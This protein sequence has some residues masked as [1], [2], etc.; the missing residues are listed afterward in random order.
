MRSHANEIVS[1]ARDWFEKSYDSLYAGIAL[2]YLMYFLVGQK[3]DIG[4]IN[5]FVL[6]STHLRPIDMTKNELAEKIF[7]TYKKTTI[8][9]EIS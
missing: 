2:L 7:R 1:F 5:K 6:N 4:A 8:N 9:K 3:G